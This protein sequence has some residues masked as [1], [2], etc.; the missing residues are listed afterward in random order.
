MWGILE[1]LKLIIEKSLQRVV[2]NLDSIEAV[3][4]IEKGNTRSGE[5][6]GVIK[7]I[8]NLMDIRNVAHLEHV[9]R[10]SNMCV[11]VLAHIGCVLDVEL[12]VFI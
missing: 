6:V 9:Y 10:E 2:I 5:G 4:A 8:R 11:G 12:I 7:N 3:T 1:G